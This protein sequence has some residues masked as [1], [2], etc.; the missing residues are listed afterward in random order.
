M[1]GEAQRAYF[2]G[3]G[4][5]PVIVDLAQEFCAALAGAHSVICAAGSAETEGAEQERQIDLDAIVK[6]V[7]LCEATWRGPLHRRQRLT[8]IR[9]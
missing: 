8:G 7:D 2:E 1:R 6:A 3:L 4:A 9:P 5:S